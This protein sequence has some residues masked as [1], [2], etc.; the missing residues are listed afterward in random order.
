MIEKRNI[1]LRCGDLS[2]GAENLFDDIE[3]AK[4]VIFYADQTK[5][6]QLQQLETETRVCMT[7]SAAALD[8][9]AIAWCK[10]RKLQ[11]ALGGPVGKEW[12]SPDCD[13]Q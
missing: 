12:G 5:G 13:Y 7:I 11:G 8:E 3:E 1:Q 9:L 2:I 6:L 10:K 4:S